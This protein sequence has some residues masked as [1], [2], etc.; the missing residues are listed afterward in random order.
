MG[1]RGGGGSR[2]ERERWSE[3]Y[4]RKKTEIVRGRRDRVIK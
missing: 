2:E 4:E 1:P 3:R